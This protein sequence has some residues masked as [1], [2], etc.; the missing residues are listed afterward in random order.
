[1]VT[2][3][4]KCS[5]GNVVLL[6]Y[7][8]GHKIYIYMGRETEGEKERFLILNK[9]EWILSGRWQLYHS[10]FEVDFGLPLVQGTLVVP[11]GPTLE[12]V[13]ILPLFYFI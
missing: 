8:V 6:R 9:K 4:Y 3:S 2:P 13:I 10:W 12:R 11:G 7:I 5:T 1:M